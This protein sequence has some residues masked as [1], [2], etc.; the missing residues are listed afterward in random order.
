MVRRLELL[1]ED[2]A[3]RCA[4]TTRAHADWP[5]HAGCSDCCRSLAEVPSLTEPEWIRL[6]DAIAALAGDARAQIEEAVA[7]RRVLGTARP[8]VCPLLDTTSGLCRVYEARPLACRTYGFYADR[9]GVLGCHRILERAERDD[10]IVWGNHDG[11]ERAQA[12]L[13]ERRS[14]LDW[15]ER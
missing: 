11:V 5:C 9:D 12:D 13:G 15:L 6:R 1:D 7:R 4:E 10:A 8:V 14:L 2:V 3:R